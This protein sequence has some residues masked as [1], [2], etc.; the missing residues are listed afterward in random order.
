MIL[1][2]RERFSQKLTKLVASKIIATSWSFYL[3]DSVRSWIYAIPHKKHLTLCTTCISSILIKYIKDK[4][5][6]SIFYHKPSSVKVFI[7]LDYSFQCGATKRCMYDFMCVQT[8]LIN[9]SQYWI[10]DYIITLL[11]NRIWRKCDIFLFSI[12]ALKTMCSYSNILR[13]IGLLHWPLCYIHL[14]ACRTMLMNIPIRS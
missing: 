7:E 3:D 6:T 1:M 4:K 12:H 14:Y 2:R 8:G 10:L 11:I 9:L 5:D 13:R